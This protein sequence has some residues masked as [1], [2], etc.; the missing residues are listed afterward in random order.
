[1]KT[2]FTKYKTKSNVVFLILFSLQVQGS[3]SNLY[4]K[5]VEF[6][7]TPEEPTGERASTPAPE[8]EPRRVFDENGLKYVRAFSKEWVNPEEVPETPLKVLKVDG[9]LY[10]EMPD[11]HIIPKAGYDL[12]KQRDE[13]SA[14][15]YMKDMKGLVLEVKEGTHALVEYNEKTNPTFR[16][17][18]FHGALEQKRAQERVQEI[19]QNPYP[20]E[21]TI[22]KS[23]LEQGLIPKGSLEKKN[24]SLYLFFNEGCEQC[25]EELEQLKRF[26]EK[27]HVIVKVAIMDHSGALPSSIHGI[28]VVNGNPLAE[29]WKIRKQPT[30]VFVEGDDT[31][32]LRLEGLITLAELEQFWRLA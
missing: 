32:K 7:Q 2:L 4:E 26:Q 13:K 19:S 9:V 16:N 30:T 6:F 8:V 29:A 28:P 11:G 20:T 27:H 3:P 31:V 24:L 21:K 23:Y 10:Q 5:D 12:V 17:L 25:H 15:R 18:R 1:M 22:L 14:E